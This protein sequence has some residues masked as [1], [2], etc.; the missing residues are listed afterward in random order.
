MGII[1]GIPFL[2]H[3]DPCISWREGT[4]KIYDGVQTWMVPMC[5]VD[6]ATHSAEGW[7]VVVWEPEVSD[8]DVAEVLAL[9]EP[10]PFSAREGAELPAVADETP[11]IVQGPIPTIIQEVIDRF[12]GVFPKEITAGLSPSRPTD[13]RIDLVPDA[14]PPC[15][16]IFRNCHGEEVEIRRQLDEYL[17]HGWIAPAHSAFGRACCLPKST[18]APNAC[19]WTIGG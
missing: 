13:H 18:M 7:P 11:G 2:R 3:F 6:N 8:P 10:M 5:I 12:G 9:S 17:A 15:H 16:C 1:L 14:V 4:L 19:A